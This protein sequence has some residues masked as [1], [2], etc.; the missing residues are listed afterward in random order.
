M[1]I[2]SVGS[3]GRTSVYLQAGQKA[4]LLIEKVLT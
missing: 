1:K 3:V 4:F 2:G